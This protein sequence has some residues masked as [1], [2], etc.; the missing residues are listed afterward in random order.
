MTSQDALRIIA[1]E[2]ETPSDVRRVPL[3]SVVTIR[4]R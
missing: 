2:R 1:S 3:S 4:G